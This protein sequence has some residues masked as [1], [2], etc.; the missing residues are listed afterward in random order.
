MGGKEV[1]IKSVLQA[2]PV[3]AM[4]CFALTKEIC[5]K[6]ESIMNKFWWTNSKSAKGIYWST[7]D[8]LCKPKCDG[9]MGFRNL[10]LFNKALLAKQVW[11]ILS[12]P[13]CLLAKVFKAR[14]FPKS[15]ILSAKVSS[16]PSFT[17]RSICGARDLIANGLFWR[18]GKGTSVNIWNDPWIPGPGNNRLLVQKIIPQLTT[19]H[20]LIEPES[21]TWNKELLVSFVA[22]EQLTSILAI[23]IHKSSL[24][25]T[26]VWKHV[27]TGEFPVKSAYRVLI[28]EISQNNVN[29]APNNENYMDFYKALWALQI[30][31]KI[32]IHVWRLFKN[33]VPHF[34]NLAK[35]KLIMDVTCPL[36]NEGAE[37]TAHLLG[38]CSVVKQLWSALQVE[39][40]FDGCTSNQKTLFVNNFLAGD[41]IKRQIISIS[42]W[43]F[44]YS[45]NKCVHEGAKFSLKENLC[46]I[47]G[48]HQELCLS[49]ASMISFSR[50]RL[51][52]FWKPPDYGFF[53][54]NFDTS[55]QK[56]NR[57]S[58]M[59]VLARDFTGE[60]VGGCTCSLENVDDPF[61]AEARACERAI[62]FADA[63]GFQRVLLEGD[64]LTVIKK[65]KTLQK[66][67]PFLDRLF[68]T[69]G[70]LRRD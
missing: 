9:G 56:E 7:W 32:K 26:M 17:W 5:R 42:L 14:Y 43:A 18:I 61:V 68:T 19:V 55:F 60:V 34:C 8:E 3:Y 20:Q 62:Q 59:A 13:N 24:E 4:Q 28:T 2:L 46:F 47:R 15:D 58:V 52:N 65:L 12:Q 33:F 54:L 49:R 38:S 69:S 36:C 30:P 66:I 48:F 40:T 25:D 51:E 11:R 10:F 41:D 6:L 21:N 70:L 37:D 27:A 63:M 29:N 50:S 1:F 35:K 45:R 31:S 53:K 57:T 44:W 39:L 64:S 67:N 16:Y 22:G 23:P